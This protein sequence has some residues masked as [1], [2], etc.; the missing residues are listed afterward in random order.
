MNERI[1]EDGKAVILTLAISHDNLM[2]V[3][4]NVFH[5]QAHTFHDAQS[6]AVHDLGD[7]FVRSHEARE[8]P[9]DFVFGEDGGDGFGA[10][11]A[12]SG[13][14]EFVEFD[15][16]DVSVEEE[17]GAEGLILCGGGDLLFGGKMGEELSDFGD[18]HFLWV[19]LV[20]EKE[21]VFDPGNVGVFCARGV[22]FDAKS[23]AVLIEQFFI[24]GGR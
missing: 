23:V 14:L 17:D 13:E 11:R 10:L 8:E 7:E 19:A 21:V 4:V 18:A 22:M 5:A 6:A 16:K 12:K 24:L 3:E 15:V 1:G 2:V 9:L 20:M